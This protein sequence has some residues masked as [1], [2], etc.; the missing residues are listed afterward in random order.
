MLHSK[1]THQED[2][3]DYMVVSI[4][5]VPEKTFYDMDDAASVAVPFDAR[6]LVNAEAIKCDGEY[7]LVPEGSD[8]LAKVV[9][10]ENRVPE[11]EV[12][13]TAGMLKKYFKDLQH[14]TLEVG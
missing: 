8:D 4:D 9:V 14:E 6:W 12:L 3:A 7:F 13:G 11:V 2:E 10:P 5:Y 1:D